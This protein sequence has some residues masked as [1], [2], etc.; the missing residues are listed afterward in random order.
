MK[1]MTHS[2][3]P[4]GVRNYL[5]LSDHQVTQFFIVCLN[6]H[7]N[8]PVPRYLPSFRAAAR[9][10]PV[11]PLAHEREETRSKMTRSLVHELALRAGIVRGGSR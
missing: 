9:N 7:F 8:E 2:R 10:R 5:L 3:V 4:G 6:V 1:A 11:K